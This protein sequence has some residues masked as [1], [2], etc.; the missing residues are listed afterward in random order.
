MML[1]LTLTLTLMLMLM[2]INARV[3]GGRCLTI[4]AQAPDL[5]PPRQHLNWS[6]W[7]LRHKV[8]H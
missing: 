3:A 7:E 8:H 5:L 2:M 1:M 4:G 6:P